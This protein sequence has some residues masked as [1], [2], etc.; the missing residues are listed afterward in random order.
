MRFHLKA[1]L[2][3]SRPID[4]AILS[5]EIDD[6]NHQLMERS[7]ASI[8]EW[9]LKENILDLS[10]VSGT[11]RRA[12]DILLNFSNVLSRKLGKAYKVGIRGI[13]VYLYE[14]RF[15]LDREPLHDIVIPFADVQ[16][17]GKEVRMVL[18]DTSEEFLRK[19]YVDRMIRLVR[20]KVENQYYEGKGEFWK[21]IWR[22]EEKDP[23]WNRDPT[24]EMLKRGW[25]VQGPTKGKWFYR[26][27]A[28]AIL[29]AMERI[30]IEEVLKPLGFQE[31]IE[32]HIVPFDIWLKTGHLEGMPGEIYYVC[33]PRSRDVKEWERFIDLVK[34][35][36]EVPEDELRRNLSLPRAGICYAQCPV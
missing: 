32:S 17:E 13:D 16:I 12:H 19:N 2:K 15:S 11:R 21:L 4:K 10:I 27:Q 14:I 35:T 7:E 8:E 23:V 26:P 3:L 18:R 5:K 1:R 31:V 25:L 30:A 22:S 29:R 28:A 36:R 9:D 6:F 20:E 24:E 33:E 34:I